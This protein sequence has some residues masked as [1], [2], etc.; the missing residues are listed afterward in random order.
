M[1]KQSRV[2]VSVL[3]YPVKASKD[4]YGDYWARYTF[5]PFEPSINAAYGFNGRVPLVFVVR[6]RTCIAQRSD[7]MESIF[8]CNCNGIGTPN[9][10]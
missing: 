9:F 8:R 5:C 10:G 2:I 3:S 1:S 7:G 6:R 4:I